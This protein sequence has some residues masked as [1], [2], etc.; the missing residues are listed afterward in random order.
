MFYNVHPQWL[1]IVKQGLACM[2]QAYLSTLS[3]S[4]DWLPGAQRLFAAFSIPLTE[5]RYVLLGESPYPRAQSANGYA[6][7][8]AAVGTL[9]SKTGLSSPVNRA[10]SLRNL[11]K[12]LLLARGDLQ[13]DFSQDAIMRLD[14]HLYI[15]T[16]ADLFHNFLDRGFLLL[17]ASLVYRADEVNFHARHWL[18]FMDSILCQLAVLTPEVQLIL[19]GKIAKNI[20]NTTLKPK[21]VAEHPYNLSFIT[22]PDVVEFFKPLNL[23]AHHD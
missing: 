3:Q 10:T 12:M 13:Q 11:M 15:Q 7:W 23:L 2:D 18:P 14:K 17:N 20:P 16:G 1:P 8:D 22:N 5:L 9:W 21:L 4:Q 6:F 19:L